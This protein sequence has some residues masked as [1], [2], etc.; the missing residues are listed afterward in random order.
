MQGTS[1]WLSWALH[2]PLKAVGYSSC[3]KTKWLDCSLSYTKMPYYCAFGPCPVGYLRHVHK[4]WYMFQGMKH[5]LGKYSY[6]NNQ[7]PHCLPTRTARFADY[8]FGT[9]GWGRV[10]KEKFLKYKVLFNKTQVNSYFFVACRWC[11]FGKWECVCRQ[12]TCSE[13]TNVQVD[14]TVQFQNGTGLHR[15]SELGQWALWQGRN[16]KKVQKTSKG[17]TQVQT[18]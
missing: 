2:Q 3:T 5:L 15:W 16:C 17:Q 12:Q 10:T 11:R 9:A 18:M 14:S 6:W 4:Q 7:L 8:N 13:S 1:S